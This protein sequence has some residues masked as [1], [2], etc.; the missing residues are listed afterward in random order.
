MESAPVLVNGAFLRAFL[1]KEGFSTV[2]L[3]LLLMTTSSVP[4][5]LLEH[6]ETLGM[7]LTHSTL[8]LVASLLLL[9]LEDTEA[10]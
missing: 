2:T 9:Y 4:A 8:A 1:A 10:L 6:L 3:V 7:S 5:V